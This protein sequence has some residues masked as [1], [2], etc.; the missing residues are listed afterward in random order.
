VRA[1][2]LNANGGL[3]SQL[4]IAVLGELDGSE[5]ADRFGLDQE[6][7]ETWERLFFAARGERS[8]TGWVHAHIIC[9]ALK[10]GNADL[11][12][13]LKLVAAGGPVA[14]RAV[15]DCDSRVPVDKGEQLFDQRL[16][17][18]VKFQAACDM[19]LTSSRDRLAFIRLHTNM[20]SRE[21]RLQ[22][23]ERK[24][25][26]RCQEASDKH[27]LAKLRL[28]FARERERQRLAARAHRDEERA[29]LAEGQKHVE[30]LRK[31]QRREQWEAERKAAIVRAAS[32]PLATLT[33]RDSPSTPIRSQ[34]PEAQTARASI[35][36]EAAAVPCLAFPLDDSSSP[37]AVAVPA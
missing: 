37:V 17:M 34:K 21:K 3:T 32:S 16:K 29:L 4:Q 33:W 15:L 28:E 18:H 12:A 11:A 13:R 31:E 19:P 7:L 9:P 1:E 14:A 5:I 23:E 10:A 25:E 22:L 8:R 36:G 24:L 30:E 6:T 35:N 27:E 2:N 26:Q 20:M